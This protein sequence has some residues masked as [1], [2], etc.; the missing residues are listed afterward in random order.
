MFLERQEEV[1]EDARVREL[2]VKLGRRQPPHSELGQA[3]LNETF[4]DPCTPVD[5][6]RRCQGTLHIC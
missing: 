6:T 2:R 4:M 1:D 3:L 5:R